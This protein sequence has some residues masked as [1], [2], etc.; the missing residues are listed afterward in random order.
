K[1]SST[2]Q[3]LFTMFS[4]PLIFGNT[5]PS[6]ILGL[7]S[8]PPDFD[9]VRYNPT[10]GHYEPVNSF[11]PGLA[12]W[13]RSRL[14]S[15]R[16]ILIDSV[17]FPPLDNQ[18]QPNAVPF[19]TVYPRGWNKIGNPYIYGIRF[20]EIQ[21]FDQATLQF[22]DINTAADPLHQWVLP[23]VYHYDTND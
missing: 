23:A 19:K 11:T 4:F 14:H 16:T 21:V 10:T 1:S 5:P 9:L 2:T 15:D 22:I 17:K 20:S 12:Y 3:G 18:V 13:L 8:N 7:N 6:T